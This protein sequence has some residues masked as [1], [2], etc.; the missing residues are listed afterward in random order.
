MV[1][2]DECIKGLLSALFFARSGD[3]LAGA[4]FAPHSDRFFMFLAPTSLMP[5][6]RVTPTVTRSWT[7]MFLASGRLLIT[8]GE[9]VC[10]VLSLL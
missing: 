3:A 7:L 6:Y 8:A 4:T 2:K 5:P 10:C 1:T 9:E